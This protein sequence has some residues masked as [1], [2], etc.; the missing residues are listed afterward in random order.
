MWTYLQ[1]CQ[2]SKQKP[3]SQSAVCLVRIPYYALCTHTR[4]CSD[5]K[6]CPLRH[7][8]RV[9]T[10]QVLNDLTETD[11]QTDRQTDSCVRSCFT[12]PKR[13]RTSASFHFLFLTQEGHPVS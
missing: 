6:I 10:P 3:E 13:V 1:R 4:V 2:I 11:R 5:K 9:R 12:Q 8:I 7:N